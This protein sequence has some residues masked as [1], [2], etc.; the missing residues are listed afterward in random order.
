MTREFIVLD[1]AT[2]VAAATADRV[3]TAGKEAIARQGHFFVA[4]TGGST[5]LMVCPLLVVPPRVNALDWSKVDFFFGDERA[6]PSRHPESNYNLARNAFLDYLPGVRPGQVHRMIGEAADLDAAC[7]A[8]EALIARTVGAPHGAVSAFDLIWLGM[9]SDGHTASLFQDTAAMTERS[10]WVV[11]NWVPKLD[12]WRLTM[13]YPLLNAARE[14]NF[15]VTGA[16]KA[17]A[18]ASVRDGSGEVPAARVEADRTLWFV[19][20]AAAGEEAGPQA[21]TAD[22]D[23]PSRAASA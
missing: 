1:D 8:Y 20:R 19:D 9:G 5:P 7:R 16:D 4:L 6:V 23:A 3:I 10:R 13:T 22:G 15:V 2:S 18:L 11:P 21:S 12:A 17:P 14:V